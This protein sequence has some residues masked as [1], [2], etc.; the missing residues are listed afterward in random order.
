ML[1]KRTYCAQRQLIVY[2]QRFFGLLAR[3]AAYFSSTCSDETDALVKKR[4]IK[5]AKPKS[6]S[7]QDDL[8]AFG[9][10]NRISS[11]SQSFKEIIKESETLSPE[12]LFGQALATVKNA[13]DGQHKDQALKPS[14]KR[15][16]KEFSSL[17]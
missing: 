14:V 8:L 15:V 4:R 13:F 10:N 17:V 7:F 1:F 2:H 6:S 9:Q 3:K 11:Q 5:T 16:F 12:A